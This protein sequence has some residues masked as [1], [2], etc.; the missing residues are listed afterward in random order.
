MSEQKIIYAKPEIKAETGKNAEK[1][2]QWERELPGVRL[3]GYPDALGQALVKL[4]RVPVISNRDIPGELDDVYGSLESGDEILLRQN[5]KGQQVPS[6]WYEYMEDRKDIVSGLSDY[7]GVLAKP[8]IGYFT[9][10]FVDSKK[11]AEKTISDIKRKYPITPEM[12]ASYVLHKIKNK[13]EDAEKTRGTGGKPLSMDQQKD[14]VKADQEYYKKFDSFLHY[15]EDFNQKRFDNLFNQVRNL[16]VNLM[17]SKNIEEKATLAREKNLADE[18]TRY[19]ALL[20]ATKWPDSA[21]IA[22]SYEARDNVK[23]GLEAEHPDIAK[24]VAVDEYKLT[25]KPEQKPQKSKK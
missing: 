1:L 15:V 2:I 7:L 22:F 20:S 8:L 10:Y 14:M 11:D 24:R 25:L 17:T 3:Y 16:G 6:R 4:G 5:I 19:N 13:L 23:T 18:F 21:R 12:N 9:G